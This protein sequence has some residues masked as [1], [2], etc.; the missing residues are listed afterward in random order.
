LNELTEELFNL[1]EKGVPI[2]C[3]STELISIEELE[4]QREYIKKKRNMPLEHHN[5]ITCL[6]RVNKQLDEEKAQQMLVVCTE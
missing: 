4:K 6:T 3:I 2:S 1:R 5:Y